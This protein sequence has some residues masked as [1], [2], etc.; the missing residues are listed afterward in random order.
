LISINKQDFPG[1]ESSPLEHK[2]SENYPAKRPTLGVWNSSGF[3]NSIYSK[4][5]TF[6][7]SPCFI[8]MERRQSI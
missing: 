5:S 6:P 1:H 2:E 8:E 3:L 7:L 4:N